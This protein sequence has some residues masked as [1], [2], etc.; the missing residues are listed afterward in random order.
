LPYDAVR[1]AMTRSMTDS[2]NGFVEMDYERLVGE[3]VGPSVPED[4][5]DGDSEHAECAGVL[6]CSSRRSCA[7]ILL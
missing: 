2:W 7:T 5:L 4:H 1:F 3:V 6:G